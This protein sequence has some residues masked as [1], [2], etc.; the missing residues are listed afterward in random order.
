MF[1]QLLAKMKTDKLLLPFGC[2]VLSILLAGNTII[3][4]GSTIITGVR[5]VTKKHTGKP[6]KDAKDSDTCR[7]KV[8]E[9]WSKRPAWA[10]THLL[11][12][13]RQRGMIQWSQGEG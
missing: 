4:A 11:L 6:Y 13:E 12:G 2:E 9:E 3:K 1:C 5:K 10:C 8:T 7:R